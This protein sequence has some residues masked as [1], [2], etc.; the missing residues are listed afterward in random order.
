MIVVDVSG[1]IATAC[2]A[3]DGVKPKNFSTAHI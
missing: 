3:H 2:P 1:S